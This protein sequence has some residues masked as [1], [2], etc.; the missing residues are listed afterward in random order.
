MN[1]EQSWDKRL[2]KL[3][4]IKQWYLESIEKELARKV[5]ADEKHMISTAKWRKNNRAKINKSKREYYH[6]NKVRILAQ[7]KRYLK[8]L[9]EDTKQ[10]HR[11]SCKKYYR[12]NRQVILLQHKI[13]SLEKKLKEVK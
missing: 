5:I 8:K 13:W 2:L 3:P 7:Q 1:E 9:S 4:I 11:E 6:K 10:K 12:D